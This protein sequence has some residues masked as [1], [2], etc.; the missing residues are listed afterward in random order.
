MVMKIEDLA[1]RISPSGAN[2][3]ISFEKLART[4]STH[5]DIRETLVSQIKDA[6][7]K[8]AV[9]DVKD[10]AIDRASF[11]IETEARRDHLSGFEKSLLAERDAFTSQRDLRAQSLGP[12]NFVMGSANAPEWN[13]PR[14]KTP[15][16]QAT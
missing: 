8:L 10:S 14:P 16:P 1:V 15:A 4:R 12:V 6:E 7:Q 11:R 9:L 5:A 2:H 3:Q 13:R